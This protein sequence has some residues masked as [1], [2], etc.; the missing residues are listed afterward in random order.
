MNP[1]SPQS[2]TGYAKRLLRPLVFLALTASLLWA[3]IGT[4]H[5]PIV[6]DAPLLHYIV[7]LHDH[8]MAPYTQVVD[9]NLPGT[10]ALEWT[11]MHLFG[12]G[13]LAWRCFDF[14]LLTLC[15][16]S[17]VLIAVEHGIDWLA[18]FFAAALFALIHF[19]DGPTHTG[20]R[21]LMMTAMLLPAIATLFYATDLSSRPKR[22]AVERSAS[23]TTIAAIWPF[24]LF[25]FSL[26]MA[27]IIKPSGILFA[28]VL[29]TLLWIHLGKLHRPRIASLTY[30][31]LGFLTPILATVVWLHH[32]GA[33]T[34]F[35]DTMRGLDA[36]HASLGRPSLAALIVGSFP[37]VLLAVVIPA[38]ALFFVTKQGKQWPGLILIACILLGAVSYILQGKGYPYHR[39][40]T[41]AFLLLTISLLAFPLL[42]SESWHRFPALF[43][44]L[45]GALFLAPVSASIA[46]HYDWRNQEF[47]RSLAS[48]LTTLGGSALNKNVQCIDTTAGC[49]N[50]LYNLQLVQ[51]TGYL[52]D[53]YL[54][55]PQ[56]APAREQ[57]REGFWNALQQS[58]PQVIVLSDQECFTM[59]RSFSLLDR[60][61]QFRSLLQ[62][63]YTLVTQRTP[64]HT[65]AWWRHPA[66][67][68]SYRIYIRNAR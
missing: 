24:A 30:A 26:G 47:N 3:A 41:E 1:A 48:D 32:H 56:P 43:T 15:G 34:A 49:I 29:L 28:F 4:L 68:F 17:M 7:F 12:P 40:P 67:P 31:K 18:G 61:P 57:Y 37:S 42:Q 36:Y 27:T 20:Q 11:A 46:C 50:T 39:Y 14:L 54:F 19:R 23:R 38:L 52:Y 51:A 59:N 21:D 9:I 58:H 35:L 16:V 66:Q 6:G 2:A 25:G 8:G 53:C 44:V 65:I 63:D 10:Y 13:P 33:L 5:W 60:W 45:L 64:P 62:N 22:S 55:Q